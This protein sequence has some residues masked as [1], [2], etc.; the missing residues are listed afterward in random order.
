VF[1]SILEEEEVGEEKAKHGDLL[2][3]LRIISCYQPW[4]G[5]GINSM[6]YGVLKIHHAFFTNLRWLL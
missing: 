2:C 1:K 4:G 5:L 6:Y 3:T